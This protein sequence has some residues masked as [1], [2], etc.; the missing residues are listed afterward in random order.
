[1]GLFESKP[2]QK[3]E[4]VGSTDN[5]TEYLDRVSKEK[6]M[7]F[8]QKVAD[9]ERKK[10]PFVTRSSRPTSESASYRLSSKPSDK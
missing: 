3:A 4:I 9:S 1:M 5:L 10:E 8:Q 7:R 2:P 6:A